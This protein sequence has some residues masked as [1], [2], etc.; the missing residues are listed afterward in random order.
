MIDSSL[1]VF[2]LRNLM[3]K[4]GS[5]KMKYVVNK[6]MALGVA[7][8]VVVS[9]CG[10]IQEPAKEGKESPPSTS[11]P[12]TEPVTLRAWIGG[13]TFTEDL[14]KLFR[15]TVSAKLPHITLEF[16]K[17]GKNTQLEDLIVAGTIPDMLITGNGTLASYREM[18]GILQDITPLLKPAGIDLSG[19]NEGTI[20]DMKIDFPKGELYGIPYLTI[21]HA[22]YYNKEIFDKFGVPYPTDGMTW[23]QVIELAKKVTVIQDGVQYRGL[24]TANGPIYPSQ[25]LSLSVV[26]AKTER[27]SINND[28]WKRV[29]EQIGSIYKIPGNASVGT[30]RKV[31]LEERRLA[32]LGTT[33][34]LQPLD[35]VSNEL[36]WDVVQYPSYK[37]KPNVYGNSS[38]QLAVV[39]A[40]SKHKEQ[41]L[42]VLKA[43]TSKE[44]QMRLSRSGQVS[45]L[46]DPEIRQAFA[47]DKASMKG[48]NLQGIFK[49]KAVNYP[50]S[51]EFRSKAE[52][53]AQAKFMEY[54]TDKIDVNTALRL[55]EE[56]INKM[57]EAEKKK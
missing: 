37:D 35:E 47:A 16:I 2:K 50:P 10:G 55:S 30:S 29:F 6:L 24:D 3:I 54:V 32:M 8:S 41:V 20:S 1:P 34:F 7:L 14:E 40:A 27:A 53:I 31:F 57:I 44:A 26:D 4:R 48:K 56:E 42:Q 52:V 17:S 38:S 12:S 21:F 49:S 39:T 43:V 23:E 13:V 11:T 19:F 5:I 18:G 51:S 22:L 25:P 28:A 15:D 45:V 9:G 46:T 33:N 36:N